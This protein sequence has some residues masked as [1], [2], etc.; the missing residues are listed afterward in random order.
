MANGPYL[1]VALDGAGAHPAAWRAP[2]AARGLFA[3][4]RLVDLAR[5]AE[6]GR[7]RLR[8]PRRRRSTRRR[9]RVGRVAGPARRPAGAGPG[10]AGHDHRSAS[11]PTVTTTHTEPFHISKNVATLDLVSGGRAG[12]RVAVST[13]AEAA[14]RFGR[15][16]AA[17]LG[18]LWAEADDAIEVVSRLWDSW[19]DDAVIR[20][21]ATG[22]YVDRDK[23]H[24]IDFEGAFF[25]VR[26]PSIT[27]RSP[28]G[29]PL[30]DGRRRRT[31]TPRPVAAR[32]AD[33]V[34]VDVRRRRRRPPPRATTSAAAWPRPAAI[35]TTSPC[36]PIARVG[37]PAL[38]GRARP[39]R[40]PPPPVPALDLVGD[41][42]GV[43]D[44]LEA[45]SRHG[46]VDG[47]LVRP[48]VLPTTLD[49]FVDEVVPRLEAATPVGTGPRCATA[50]G[51]P[52]RP[53]ATPPPRPRRDPPQADPPRRPLP[54]RQQHDGLERSRR[55]AARPT[56][57][58][59]CTSPRP[60]SGASS[61][62]SSSPR[63]CACASTAVG[64]STSTSSAG[65]T[66]S[67]CWPRWPRS[68]TAS[69][70]RPR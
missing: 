34:L 17:P 41:A 38:R 10:G 47:F 64:S 40:T 8:R 50:S 53:T 16:V 20:D 13:T 2:G 27:P 28:Q 60:P 36:S 65:R 52:A 59:S 62:S 46:A 23:L 51:S 35:P 61:T 30:V 15:K 21:R 18:E 11:S 29:Q 56:S 54:G 33:I 39:A 49:W 69:V 37:E 22:R 43:A 24:Y 4:E 63:A 67:P 32:R 5:T 7:A 42:A 9:P 25:S 3:A 48:D 26:G 45:W 1:G 66:R 12:W 55:P 31:T 6:R 58:R 70:W 14:R 68:P 44:A 19:E 57:P